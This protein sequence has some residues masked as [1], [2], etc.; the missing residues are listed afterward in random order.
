MFKY[1]NVCL[2]TFGYSL[3]PRVLSSADIESSLAPLYDRL[4]LPEGRL[5]LMSGI[6]ERR[7]WPKGMKPSEAAY[8][9][10]K[11]TLDDGGI[12]AAEVECL[13]FTSVCRD[14]MEPATSAF[15]H[16]KLGLPKSCLVFDISNACLGFLDGMVMLANMIELGQVKNGLVVSGE[17]AEDLLESTIAAL[18]ADETFTRKTIKSSFASLTIGSGSVGCFMRR[19]EAGETKPRL[20]RGVWRTDTDHI[21]LCQGDAQGGE[22]TLMQTDSEELLLRGV[23]TAAAAWDAFAAPG[24]RNEEVD[25]Y[26][27]HQ[28]GVAHFRMLFDR[29][30]L[31]EEKNFQ[32]LPFLGNV[33]TVSAPITL[34]MAMEEGAFKP[35]ERAVMLGIG[36]GINS[37]VLGIDW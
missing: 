22:T 24:W 15:V 20:V 36:S 18:N 8:L 12:A 7:L 19:A 13:L 21:H 23:D 5:E 9:A 2:D 28:V 3:P 33:G 30:G 31:S 1:S 10:G 17:T 16:H 32:T 6:R 4:H 35:G 29:L 25:A 14:M 37:I 26:C 11:K 34:A 27:C